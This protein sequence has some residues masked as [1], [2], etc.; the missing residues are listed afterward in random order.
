MKDL[1][2]KCYYR[3]FSEKSQ[4]FTNSLSEI[5]RIKSNFWTEVSYKDCQ[6]KVEGKKPK[7]SLDFTK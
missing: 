5:S 3:I 7:T 4:L 6:E 1:P 2:K